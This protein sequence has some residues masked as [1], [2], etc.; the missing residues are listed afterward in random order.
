MRLVWPELREQRA[1]EGARPSRAAQA[2]AVALEV[3]E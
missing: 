2:V 3:L 1:R